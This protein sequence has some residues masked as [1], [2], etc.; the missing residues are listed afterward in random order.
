MNGCWV[1]YKGVDLV[2][3]YK[4]EIFVFV[5]VIVFCVGRNGGYGNFIEF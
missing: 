2:G 4:I 3:W 5:D 1:F